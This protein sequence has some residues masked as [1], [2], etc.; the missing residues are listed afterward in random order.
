M[1]FEDSG[2]PSFLL[3]PMGTVGKIRQITFFDHSVQGFVGNIHLFR[4]IL[5]GDNDFVPIFIL[6]HK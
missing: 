2:M 3:G 6:T 4:D 5:H 1:A